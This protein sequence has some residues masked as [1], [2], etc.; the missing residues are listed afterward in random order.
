AE[1]FTFGA[2]VPAERYTV[3]IGKANVVREGTDLTLVTLSGTVAPSLTA[4]EQA[5]ASGI[6]VEVIDLRSVVPLDID[7]VASSVNKTG[8][9]LVV[10]EDYLSF[11]LSAEVVTR[12][13]ERKISIKSVKRLAVPDVPIPGAL[14]LEREIVPNQESIGAAIAETVGKL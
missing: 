4:A 12:L 8:K 5:K 1:D 7:T 9:I 11:G 14:S 6:S 13:L 2:D 10:D 3:P